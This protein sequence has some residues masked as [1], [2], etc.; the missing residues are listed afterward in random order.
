MLRLQW[1]CDLQRTIQSLRL[2]VRQ[3]SADSS[4]V[5]QQRHM[6]QDYVYHF[7]HPAELCGNVCK[8]GLHSFDNCPCFVNLM[9]HKNSLEFLTFF[10]QTKYGPHA[11]VHD[12]HSLENV[13]V[14][15]MSY[16]NFGNTRSG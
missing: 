9:I 6:S 10:T 12:P 13:Q 15:E 14:C 4:F 8:S 3:F 1:R 2:H 16:P 7:G 5:V 11:V